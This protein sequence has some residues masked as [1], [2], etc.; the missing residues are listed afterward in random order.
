MVFLSL[1]EKMPAVGRGV[2]A[3]LPLQGLEG[4][5]DSTQ[6]TPQGSKCKLSWW[7]SVRAVPDMVHCSC[8]CAS[9]AGSIYWLDRLGLNDTFLEWWRGQRASCGCVRVKDGFREPEGSCLI[10]GNLSSLGAAAHPEQW[11]SHLNGN[12]VVFQSFPE[13][14]ADFITA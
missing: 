14:E 6:K 11:R 10:R 5:G 9:W 7:L 2:Q 3:A 1:S 12:W 8:G 4:C 13:G